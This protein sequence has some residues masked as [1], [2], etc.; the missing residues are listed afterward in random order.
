MRPYLSMLFTT[1]GL[2]ASLALGPAA[3][4]SVLFD[5]PASGY[6]TGS[7]SIS[8]LAS[9][10]HPNYAYDSFTLVAG[11]T[12]TGARF[13]SWTLRGDTVQSVNWLIYDNT[14]TLIA[15]GAAAVASTHFAV[16]F[17]GYDINFNT[18]SIASLTPGA[19]IYALLLDGAASASGRNV[20]WDET[21][22]NSQSTFGSSQNGPFPNSFQILGTNGSVPEPAS[23]A[24]MMLGTAA[25]GAALRSR[26][27]RLFAIA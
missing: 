1:A 8:G 22:N 16:N 26:R 5:S 9:P 3:Q 19:G 17:S 18:F 20:G 2:L 24:L 13:D 10:G 21:L 27:K 23:W 6:A 15:S 14:F 25:L 11:Q 12:I 7:D 4:A